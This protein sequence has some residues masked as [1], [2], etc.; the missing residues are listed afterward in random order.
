MNS[1]ETL[2]ILAA[3]LAGPLIFAPLEHNLEP[4][5]F[6]LGLIAVTFSR[7]WEW[8]LLRKT[9]LDPLPLAMAVVVAGILFGLLRPALDRG[10]AALRDL[11]SRPVLAGLT[12]LL[13]GLLSSVITAVIA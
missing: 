4:Y 1:L 3:L 10:F 13:V 9:A 5:C 8:Q 6:I 12:V 7:Q 2:L 11:L